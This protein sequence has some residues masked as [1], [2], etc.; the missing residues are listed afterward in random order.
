VSH[1]GTQAINTTHPANDEYT[2][3]TT[4]AYELHPGTPL[5]HILVHIPICR[6]A[7]ASYGSQGRKAASKHLL[8]AITVTLNQELPR[9]GELQPPQVVVGLCK[10][11]KG[12]SVGLGG[13]REQL[14]IL[15][16]AGLGGEAEV[17]EALATACRLTRA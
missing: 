3:N 7:R 10:G 11:T 8:H 1:L 4:D 6:H 12:R 17:R 14:V 15:I 9:F 2:N 16:L 13:G 5:V